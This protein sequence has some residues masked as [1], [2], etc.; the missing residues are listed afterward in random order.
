MI[1][2]KLDKTAC[3]ASCVLITGQFSN[4]SS[5]PAPAPSGGSSYLSGHFF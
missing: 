4:P 1:I 2:Y 3:L 5:P